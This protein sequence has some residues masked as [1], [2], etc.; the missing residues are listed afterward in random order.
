MKIKLQV[1]AEEFLTSL[2]DDILA[3]QSYVFIQAM[4]VEGDSAGKMLSGLLLSAS[5]NDKRILID[6]FTKFKLSDKFLYFPK[7][8]FDA[9]LRKEVKETKKMVRHLGNSGVKVKFVNPYFGPFLMRFV[10]RNHKKMVVIDDKIAYIG[11]INFSEHNFSWH[12]MMLRIE[13]PDIAEYLK[14]DFLSTWKG[15]NQNNSRSFGEVEF[16]LFDGYSNETTFQSIIRLIRGAKDSIWV[17]SPYL[18]FPF[19][20]ELKEVRGRGVAVTLITPEEN[21]KKLIKEYILWESARSGIDLKL[22]KK[23]MSHLKAILI[24]DKYLLVGSANFDYLS[25]SSQQ[26]IVAVIT[27]PEVIST[28][29]K[30]VIEEDLKNSRNFEGQIDSCKGNFV[31]LIIQSLGR[32]VTFLS[33]V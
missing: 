18:T 8:L 26:E 10:A 11:G 7:N 29:R 17:L 16:H 31:N 28:F 12:D 25:Y 15:D 19:F 21:N 4:S 23:K 2:E 32:V 13:D 1:D 27:N 30:R 33:R 9:E 20:K 24:D 14:R 3:S 5:A 6:S 22:Y